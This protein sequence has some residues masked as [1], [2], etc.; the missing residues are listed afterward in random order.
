MEEL[1]VIYLD[2]LEVIFPDRP[3]SREALA[4]K[5]LTFHIFP[6]L[7]VV[8]HVFFSKHFR[9]WSIKYE[10]FPLTPMGVLPNMAYFETSKPG[11]HQ[12]VVEVSIFGCF[13][14][15]NY[16]LQGVGGSPIWLES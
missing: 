16:I 1:Q 12:N 4:S 2:E 8:Q 6:S 13:P 10:K 9:G 15:R 7:Y 11:F 14:P 5:N 3:S